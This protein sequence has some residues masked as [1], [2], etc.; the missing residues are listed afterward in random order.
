MGTFPNPTTQFQPGQS[1]NP[2]GRPLR[3]S[4][5]VIY[6]L[7]EETKLEDLPRAM[8]QTLKQKYGGKS[9]KEAL[10]LS[11]MDKILS[12]GPV[13][14]S[15]YNAVYDRLE[16]KANQTVDLDV[17]NGPEVS[18]RELA[19]RLASVLT[20]GVVSPQ[21]SAT[22]ALPQQGDIP[23]DQDDE[24]SGSGPAGVAGSR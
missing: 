4:A 1:G 21:E 13:S 22:G 7:L 19:R 11:M 8:Q 10:A 12:E 3:P 16:G 23:H 5:Q 2:K 9:L 6:K 18:D 17:T 20:G 14:V 15:A 24:G